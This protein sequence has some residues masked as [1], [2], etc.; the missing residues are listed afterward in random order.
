M[1]KGTGQVTKPENDN[2]GS[3]YIEVFSK[4]PF[5]AYAYTSK[6]RHFS[7]MIVPNSEPGQTV[8]LKPLTPYIPYQ[9]LHQ[10]SAKKQ[11]KASSYEKSLVD[12]LKTSMVH[13]IPTGYVVANKKTLKKPIFH[14]QKYYLNHSIKAKLIE[15]LLGDHY[16]VRIIQLKNTTHHVIVIQEYNI[17]NRGVQAIALG[18]HALAPKHSTLAYEV[19]NN[20]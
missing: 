16:V 14:I 2:T 5:T 18:E 1:P 15:G 19:V 20:V 9:S 11:E 6:G 3:R 4:Q 13:D 12:V 10:A 8:E 17:F 7:F